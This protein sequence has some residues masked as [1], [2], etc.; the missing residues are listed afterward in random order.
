MTASEFAGLNLF[1]IAIVLGVL[2][3][4]SAMPLVPDRLWVLVASASALGMLWRAY[5]IRPQ[6][7]SLLLFAIY[8]EAIAM[9]DGASRSGPLCSSPS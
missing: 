6:L 1:R 7:L 8:P 9:A 4:W 5:P 3:V 2:L